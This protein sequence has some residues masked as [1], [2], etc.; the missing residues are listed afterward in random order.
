MYSPYIG[1]IKPSERYL[2]A[3]PPYSALPL[4]SLFFPHFFF[5]SQNCLLLFFYRKNGLPRHLPRLIQT[6]SFHNKCNSQLPAQP[7]HFI[8]SLATP[9]QGTKKPPVFD[10]RRGICYNKSTKRGTA[11]RRSTSDI[12]TQTKSNRILWPRAVTFLC[13]LCK[14][15]G[16]IQ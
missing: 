13:G 15:S 4:F 9:P 6:D 2:Q 12:I 11:D 5:I 16:L 3:T 10:I 8:I 7:S 1:I 14:Q